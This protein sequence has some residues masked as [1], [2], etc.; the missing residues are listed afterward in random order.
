MPLPAGVHW[1]DTTLRLPGLPGELRRHGRFLYLSA[2][3]RDDVV[4]D[5]RRV[6][7]LQLVRTGPDG[8]TLIEHAGRRW[9]GVEQDGRLGLRVLDHARQVAQDGR[10]ARPPRPPVDGSVPVNE[11]A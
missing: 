2:D 9:S 4:A 11:E 1:V 5:G 6:D 8:A 7:G 10:S 3:R